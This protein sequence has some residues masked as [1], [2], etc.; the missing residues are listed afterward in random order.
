VVVPKHTQ[1]IR[2]IVGRRRRP[3]SFAD[4]AVNY[5]AK[6]LLGI[7]LLLPTAAGS[8]VASFTS[9][10]I[11]G[12]VSSFGGNPRGACTGRLGF[13][14]NYCR[15]IMEVRRF[16]PV[17]TR[18]VAG[19]ISAYPDLSGG[20]YLVGELRSSR[21]QRAL[22]VGFQLR[23]YRKRLYRVDHRNGSR[24]DRVIA[25]CPFG[26]VGFA[27]GT[28]G[29]AASKQPGL[30]FGDENGTGYR[31]SGEAL[32]LDR[33]LKPSSVDYDVS[34][35]ESSQPHGVVAGTDVALHDRSIQ[36]IFSDF[37]ELTKPRIVTMILIVTAMS[38]L[39]AAGSELDFVLLTHLMLGTA[40]V[41]ASAG[42]LNQWLER[43][44]D[45]RMARTRFRPLPDQRVS[46]WASV[47]FGLMLIS[48][49]TP[50]L[51]VT[52]GWVP[53][54]LGLLTWALYI[55]VYTPMKT[56][57]EWNT[58][59]GA[60]AGALPMLMG[61]T[62]AGGS[63]WDAQG[64]LLFA[65]L[66]FWQFPH[67]MAIAWMYRYDYGAAGLKMTPVVEPT[68]RRA[69]MQAIIG[70]LLLVATMVGFVMMGSWGWLLAVAAV[71]VTM[72]FIVAS[73]RFAKQPDDL[74]ARRLLRASILQLPAAM[75]VLVLSTF[76]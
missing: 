47:V 74:T 70:S 58:T 5:V 42:V 3:Q 43:E 51:A 68:G 4:Q 49:G 11:A 75:L 66:V 60:I 26:V 35:N 16:G 72:K 41:A 69:G 64:W 25:D 32:V 12:C 27:S 6:C 17:A 21:Q 24:S 18:S 45:G 46:S 34:R 71:A 76:I 22:V 33:P 30:A 14:W 1:S 73:F 63:L 62:A 7:D 23:D 9:G 28:Y 19:R 39:V 55:G 54:M 29:A 44:L 36:A 52:T 53:A 2:N 8:S 59:V 57:T 20:R 61:Y 56:R 40:M 13:K 10:R 65:V 50:Y 31:M 15:P 67:F 37:V 38:A 48:L